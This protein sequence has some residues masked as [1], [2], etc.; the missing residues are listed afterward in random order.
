MPSFTLPNTAFPTGT[1]VSAYDATGYQTF[2]SKPPGTAVATAEVVDGSVTFEDLTDKTPYFAA[3]QVAGEWRAVHFVVGLDSET[4]AVETA[5]LSSGVLQV[6][7]REEQ[8]DVATQSELNVEASQRASIGTKLE[9]L[10]I[11]NAKD[12]GAKGDGDDYTTELKE[13]IHEAREAGKPLY[14]P[15]GVYGTTEKLVSPS[16]EDD[17]GLAGFVI[18]GDGKGLTVVESTAEGEQVFGALGGTSYGTPEAE[19]LIL[20]D[21]AA[22]QR[23]LKIDTT[24]E[25][26]LQVGDLLDLRESETKFFGDSNNTQSA[27]AGEKVRIRSIDG[28]EQVTLYGR[29]DFAYKAGKGVWRKPKLVDRL[30]VSDMTLV[31]LAES[32]GGRGIAFT[33]ARDIEILDVEFVGFADDTIRFQ[34]VFDFLVRGCEFKFLPDVFTPYGVAVA[35]YSQGGRVIGNK[36]RF[37]RHLFTTVGSESDPGAAHILV[38][39][40]WGSES[41]LATYDTHADA[42]HVAFVGNYSHGGAVGGMAQQVRG[43]ECTVIGLVADNLD[44][45]INIPFGAHKTTVRSSRLT[46]CTRNVIVTASN[47]VRIVDLDIDGPGEYAVEVANDSDFESVKR[48]D[49]ERIRVKGNPSGPAFKFDTWDSSFRIKDVRAPDAATPFSGRKPGQV[50]DT[51]IAIQRDGGL[52]AGAANTY[53]IQ[54]NAITSKGQAG[55]A[56]AA[57]YFDPAEYGLHPASTLVQL[58]VMLMANDTPSGIDFKIGLRPVNAVSGAGAV[59]ASSIGAAVE[60]TEVTFSKP[61]KEARL[62]GVSS[63]VTAPTAGHYVLAFVT[64]EAMAASSAIMLHARLLV[65]QA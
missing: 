12:F 61:A 5:S 22:G 47:D 64:G 60:G 17:L 14:V 30:V 27:V 18:R 39:S 45:G 57:F 13:A 40:N 25:G 2:P 46:N 55:S 31:Q 15:A 21:A 51:K 20:A 65:K 19:R 62:H 16:L 53:V 1:S 23:V 11:L 38:A 32:S 28:P 49:L 29:L 54:P 24:K 37:G 10:G 56:L 58:E 52:V 42:H 3:A 9:N 35:G 63:E 44:V 36:Q 34:Q 41:Y 50:T 8:L 33:G 59:E 7:G 4:V 48:L 26:G 6:P 43:R